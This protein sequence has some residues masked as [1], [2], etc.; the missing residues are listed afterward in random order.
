MAF[1][2]PSQPRTWLPVL[3]ILLALGGLLRLLDLSDPPLDFHSTRQLRNSLVAR[4]I[5]YQLL[6]HAD[7]QKAELA[8]SF[9][10][11]V[12][13]YEP[14]IIESLVGWTYTWTGGEN[15]ATPR[16]YQTIFW[17]L[18]GLALFDLAHRAVSPWAALA[19]LA[20][21]LVLPFSVQASRSFQPDPLMTSA[22][23]IGI[24]FLYRWSETFSP[25]P[26]GEGPGV[27]ENAWFWVLLAG[28]FL[29]FAVLVKIVIAFLVGVV[30]VAVVLDTLG[31]R[32]WKSPQVWVMAG[33]TAFPALGYYVLGHP[34]RSSEYFFSWTVALIKLIA[35]TEFYARWLGFLGSLFGLTVIFLSLAGV[36]LAPSR[37]RWLLLGAWIGYLL[38][39]LTLPFQMYTHSYYHL[40]LVPLVALGLVPAAQALLERVNAQGRGWRILLAGLVLS[41]AGYQAWVSRS[42][43]VAEDFRHEPVF[44][45]GIGAAI[46][47]DADV[48][49]LTQD[50]GYRLMYYGW[51]KAALWPLSTELAEV[52]SGGKDA[53]EKFND[54]TAG[55]DYFLVTAFGQLDKQPG[56]KAVLSEF[57]IFAQGDGFVLYDLKP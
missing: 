15:P 6:P 21:Y 18:A 26:Q 54:L 41:L 1:P 10:R 36:L 3:I 47:A 49:A 29:G 46:P 30:A 44:W 53:S 25:L 38:Y 37:L 32:F 20:Y 22:F 16:I 19:G 13:Q 7:P 48:I 2:A 31:R 40:Q 52:R 5:Y 35:S 8:A 4:D 28:L 12:G 27:R 24:Y 45:S 43:L 39:G 34:G 57:T 11:T 55:K 14:P 9:R 33:L 51:R 23:V 42:I 56:L 17:L 50:Y